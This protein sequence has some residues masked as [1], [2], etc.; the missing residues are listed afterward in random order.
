[1]TSS[2]PRR[3]LSWLAALL[4]T[5]ACVAVPGPARANDEVG[6]PVYAYYYIWFNATSWN[7][8]KSD[9]PLLGNY[10]SDERSVM[11]KHVEDAQSAGLDGFLVSWKHTPL[12]DT[13]LALLADVARSRDFSLGIVYQGLDFYRRPLPAT[14]VADDMAWFAKTY[15]RD[16]VFARSGGPLVIWAGT[17]E[18]THKEIERVSRR[19]RDGVT[20]LASQ[21]N[22]K[23]YEP[24]AGLVDGDAYYWGSMDPEVDEFAQER[25]DDLGEAVHAKGGLWLPSAAPGFDATLVGGTRVV[26]RRAG[27]TLRDE[28]RLAIDSSADAVG[29]ISWNEFSENSHI[30]PSEK[31][32]NASLSALAAILS[33]TV[34]ESIAADSSAPGNEPPGPNPW[35][36][37]LM[38]AAAIALV[39]GSLLV[40][41]WGRRRRGQQLPGSPP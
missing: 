13:R 6:I 41:A 29:V 8:A 17:W 18:F 2:V 28:W 37:G 1:M 14:R 24:V 23:E 19:V 5:I 16:E 3:T 10:S 34:P 15:G 35:R 7:R 9:F 20:L 30:E 4:T 36:V 33:A 27:Q 12:L 40:L 22:A 32:G 25:L 11:E 21:R 39:P 26:T 31:Y 38:L